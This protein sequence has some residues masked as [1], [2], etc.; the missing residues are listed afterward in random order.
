ML[1]YVMRFNSSP[2]P[3]RCMP[4]TKVMLIRNADGRQVESFSDMVALLQG[5][6]AHDHNYSCKGD[7]FRVN[8]TGRS[9][10]IGLEL[11]EVLKTVQGG[12]R[13]Q[14]IERRISGY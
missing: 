4:T 11:D 14:I 10:S 13:W 7:G 5:L 6:P 2:P 8:S 9:Y 1:T 12:G 3:R